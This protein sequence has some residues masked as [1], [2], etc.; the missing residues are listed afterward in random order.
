MWNID[1]RAE[2]TIKPPADK[3]TKNMNAVMY[4]PHEVPLFMPVT[5]R[6]NMSL[7]HPGATPAATIT[8]RT[9]MT[10]S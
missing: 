5:P 10:G 6:P 2:A 7:V 3:P 4:R 1:R 8:A 9:T